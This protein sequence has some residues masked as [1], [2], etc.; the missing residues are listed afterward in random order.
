MTSSGLF[1]PII[2]VKPA[3]VSKNHLYP[4]TL[5]VVDVP[6]RVMVVPS[7]T[8]WSGPKSPATIEQSVV[9]TPGPP[10]KFSSILIKPSKPSKFVIKIR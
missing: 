8:S 10:G 6:S 5:V 1:S 4:A 9:P 3:P 7:Q 2:S